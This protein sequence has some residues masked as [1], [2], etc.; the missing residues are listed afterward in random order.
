MQSIISKGL[1]KASPYSYCTHYQRYHYKVNGKPTMLDFIG[2]SDSN[3]KPNGIVR[4][5]TPDG[6]FFEGMVEGEIPVPNGW[7]R[8]IETDGSSYIGYY[9]NDMI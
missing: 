7:G 1:V 2:Q 3:K 8:R 6:R 5:S 4:M 9:S